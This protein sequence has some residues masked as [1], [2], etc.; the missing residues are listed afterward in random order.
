MR[1][2]LLVWIAGA[3]ALGAETVPP[4]REVY[5]KY[6]APCHGANARGG[7]GPSL[8]RSRVVVTGTREA[9]GRIVREGIPGT[10]MIPFRIADEQIQQLVTY[11]HSI[12]R[13]GEGPP[14]AGDAALGEAVF[15]KAG[16]GNC[17]M[18]N[19]A[20]GVLGPDLSS[21]ALRLFPD[22]IRHAVLEP[23]AAVGEG[24]RGVTVVTRSGSSVRG[25]LK[26]EDNFSLQV[27]RQDGQFAL[28]SRD[29][30]ERVNL[31][32]GSLMPKSAAAQL[33]PNELQNLLAFLDRQRAPRLT[34]T[35]TFQNY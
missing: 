17:H 2:F 4:G 34:F 16:C 11:L 27:L 23:D 18:V 26:R 24:Y 15:R 9:L 8:F 12:T 30:V 3:T 32:K 31:D 5:G 35:L 29:E 28:L 21:V 33:T 25:V 13:P 20:G 19:G 7:E 14:V 1:V 6:C 10:S 22:Q